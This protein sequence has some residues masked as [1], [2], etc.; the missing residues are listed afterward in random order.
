MDNVAS[1]QDQI[2]GNKDGFL[3]NQKSLLQSEYTITKVEEYGNIGKV[4]KMSIK[5]LITQVCYSYVGHIKKSK[6]MFNQAISRKD[7]LEHLSL[8]TLLFYNNPSNV[9]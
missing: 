7:S 4:H 6:R 8:I 3:K 9:S 1:C 5:C 2:D